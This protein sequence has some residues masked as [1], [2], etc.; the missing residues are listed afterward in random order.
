MNKKAL[1]IPALIGLSF[2]SF[3]LA[4]ANKS[5]NHISKADSDFTV[6]KNADLGLLD[7]GEVLS[8]NGDGVK[9]YVEGGELSTK[10]ELQLQYRNTSNEASNYWV[11]VGGYAVYVSQSATI[12]FLKLTPTGDANGYSRSAQ[13]SNLIMKADNGTTLTSQMPSGLIFGDYVDATIRFDFSGTNVVVE[14]FV[15][16]KGVTYYP[17]DSSTKITS[18]TYTSAS[19]INDYTFRTGTGDGV[20]G[21]MITFKPQEPIPNE[22]TNNGQFI[23]T[24]ANNK[25]ILGSKCSE[26]GVP[27]GN[28]GSVLRVAGLT[29]NDGTYNLSFDFTPGEIKIN[30]LESIVIRLYAES[31][32]TGAYPEFRL[33]VNGNW[34]FN[35]TGDFQG[36][37]GYSLKTVCNQWFDLTI[38]PTYFINGAFGKY[39]E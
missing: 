16:Y 30:K 27:S 21:K 7:Y 32:P 34:A 20:G 37:G 8:Y 14:F 23:Y 4:L 24:G 35:G 6:Y 3:G 25:F 19:S 39:T 1:I 10:S 33:S 22:F 12:R 38:S 36:A 13:I 11:G 29:S 28:V 18:Y 5:N 9:A 31:T 17:Y 2:T 26:E 15:E